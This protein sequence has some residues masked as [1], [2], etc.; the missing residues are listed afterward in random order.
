MA[1]EEG[2]LQQQMDELS[3]LRDERERLL[4]LQQQLH[5]L[6]DRFVEVGPQGHVCVYCVHVVCVCVCV[7]VCM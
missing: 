7:C 1:R 4:A 3:R 2:R 6:Q 5:T